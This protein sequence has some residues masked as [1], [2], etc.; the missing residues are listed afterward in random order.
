MGVAVGLKLT[1]A[2]F[3]I[4][5]A[6]ILVVFPHGLTGKFRQ[7]V[8]YGFSVLVSFSLIS[9]WWFYK[10]WINFGN[11]IFPQFNSFFKSE[12]ASA[13][14]V[15]DTR[16]GPVS[17]LEAIF[18]PFWMSFRPWRIHDA[19]LY[20][21]LWVLAYFLLIALV[22]TCFWRFFRDQK[23]ASSDFISKLKNMSPAFSVLVFIAVSYLVWLRIFSI[24]RYVIALEVLL[25]LFIYLG[26]RVIV[27]PRVALVLTIIF[28]FFSLMLGLK[29]SN[30]GVRAAWADKSYHVDVPYIENSSTATILIAADG[31]PNS[32]LLQYF[33]SQTAVLRVSG[34]FPRSLA[35]DN[36]VRQTLATRGG[37][38][39]VILSTPLDWSL[40]RSEQL[41]YK[42]GLSTLTEKPSVCNFISK[43]VAGFD[44]YKNI[45]IDINADGYCRADVKSDIVFNYEKDADYIQKGDIQLAALGYKLLPE[46]C[47]T[48]KAFVGRISMP[49]RFCEAIYR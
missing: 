14:S 44:S 1:N 21:Y 45:S 41:N 38:V 5:M 37:S 20:N 9:G 29:Q 46:S 35:Y 16:W 48:Y 19:P 7:A 22:A 11:P 32:W 40:I 23:V 42:L 28:S 31:E 49:Y 27:K 6:I 34:N 18:W 47:A 39:Y 10:I 2:P 43:V 26:S 24:G 4:A 3:A 36:R 25:P 12:L 8:T 17:G 33:P 30:F 15:I 13:T